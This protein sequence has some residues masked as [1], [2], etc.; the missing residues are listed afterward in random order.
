[1]LRLTWKEWLTAPFMVGISFYGRYSFLWSLHIWHKVMNSTCFIFSLLFL[2]HW[3]SQVVTNFTFSSE[4]YVILLLLKCFASNATKKSLVKNVEHKLEETF[5]DVVWDVHLGR[6]FLLNVPISQQLPRLTS[7][8]FFS[9]LKRPL[10]LTAP[11]LDNSQVVLINWSLLKSG[12]Y[13]STSNKLQS[14]LHAISTRV[15]Y[16]IIF[17]ASFECSDSTTLTDKNRSYTTF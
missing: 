4:S 15:I 7:L 1:M 8:Y 16:T 6:F 5:S 9:F 3:C 2:F 11:F 12:N 17:A 10:K 14:I 13:C